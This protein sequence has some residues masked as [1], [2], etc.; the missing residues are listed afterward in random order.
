MIRR[1]EHRSRAP[2]ENENYYYAGGKYKS[3][4]AGPTH[5]AVVVGAGPGGSTAARKLAERGHDVLMVERERFPRDKAC[6]GIATIGIV[7]LVGE[8]INEVVE[9][10]SRR[11]K[12]YLNMK[13][14]IDYKDPNVLFRRTRFDKLLVDLATEAGAGLMEGSDVVGIEYPGEGPVEVV[15]RSGDRIKA[16]CVVGADGPYSAVARSTGL[17]L[18][19]MDRQGNFAVYIEKDVPQSEADAILG[20]PEE[21]RRNSYFFVGMHGLGW[22]FRKE[23]GINVGIGEG[24]MGRSDLLRWARH[25]LD[26]LGMGRFKKDLRGHHI[27]GAFLPSVTAERVLLVG[28]AAGAGNPTTGCGIEDAMKTGI[29]A[30]RAL[31]SILC[32]GREPTLARLQVY[33]KSLRT[34]KRI[35]SG[36]ARLLRLL[37]GLQTRGMGT[38]FWMRWSLK[39]IGRFD[40]EDLLWTDASRF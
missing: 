5:D 40:L 33:E 25:F 29:L 12:F 23:G 9:Q 37:R 36:R 3:R 30:S 32:K 15:L 22:V 21:M 27:P 34:L 17:F 8:A 6:G 10:Y 19:L 24:T 31:D 11:T 7:D 26:D 28:D 2:D 20:P 38:E 18:P 1:T 35:Q 39:A 16:K 14:V 4:R 13:P